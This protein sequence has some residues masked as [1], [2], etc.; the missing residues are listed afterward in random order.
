MCEHETLTLPTDS[1][2]R[3]GGAKGGDLSLATYPKGSGTI[4]YHC[5]A[6]SMLMHLTPGSTACIEIAW[7]WTADHDLDQEDLDQI[8]IYPARG[9][10]IESE[11]AWFWGTSVEHNVLYQY[12]ISNA[13]TAVMTQTESL[14]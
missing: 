5:K 12:Q 1:H 6:T 3:V 2:I 10:S 13:E 11:T 7:L 9:L 14:V 8:N 4:Q